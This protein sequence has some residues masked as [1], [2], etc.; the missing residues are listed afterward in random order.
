MGKIP[1]RII[2]L[3]FILLD[4]GVYGQ[5]L[6]VRDSQVYR[7]IAIGSQIWLAQNL[8]YMTDSSQCYNA[9]SKYGRLYYQ[10]EALHI[11]PEG[12]HLPSSEEW[13]TLDT[14]VS[15]LKKSDIGNGNALK[16]INSWT[17]EKGNDE[18]GFSGLASHYFGS[19]YICRGDHGVYWTSD[20]YEYRCLLNDR[21]DLY[22]YKETY[23]KDW[24]MAVRCLMD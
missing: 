21:S 19:V 8:N 11:C 22:P 17:R 7:T 5:F 15:A 4:S 13:N 6:D 9:C 24:G 20:E 10:S 2:L 12:W 18:F 14:I 1:E 16:S 3:K 23:S